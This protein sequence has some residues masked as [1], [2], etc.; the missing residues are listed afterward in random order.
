MQCDPTAP[1][2]ISPVD[3]IGSVEAARLLGITRPT[4]CRRIASG[5]IVPLARL[6]DSSRPIFVFDRSDIEAAAR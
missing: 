6:T 2:V 1:R 3:I 4:L 5:K